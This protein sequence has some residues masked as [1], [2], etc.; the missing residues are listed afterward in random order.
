MIYCTVAVDCAYTVRC[1]SMTM[2]Y[3]VELQQMME[4][5]HPFIPPHYGLYSLLSVHTLCGDTALW[6]NCVIPSVPLDS[7]ALSIILCHDQ[8]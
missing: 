7:V 4:Q 1:I 3:A 5:I 2:A 6:F 8:L